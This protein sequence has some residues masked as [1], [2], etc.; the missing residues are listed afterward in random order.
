MNANVI[1]VNKQ[2]YKF[3]LIIFINSVLLS[4]MNSNNIFHSDTIFHSVWKKFAIDFY[5]IGLKN[6]KLYLYSVYL[7]K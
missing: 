7:Q 3:K 2:K 4:L 5:S 6:K 1:I